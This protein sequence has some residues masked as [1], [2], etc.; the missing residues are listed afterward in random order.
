MRFYS[1]EKILWR[2]IYY[3]VVLMQNSSYNVPAEHVIVDPKEN[4]EGNIL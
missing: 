3:L 2:D 1:G 4:R